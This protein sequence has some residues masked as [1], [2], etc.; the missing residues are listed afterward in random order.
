MT[1]IIQFLWDQMRADLHANTLPQLQDACH[2][3]A[4]GAVGSLTDQQREDLE[5]LERSVLKL[6]RRIEGEPI[7][8]SNH[9]EAAHALRGPLN[10]IIGFSRL[11]LKGIDGPFT[12]AQEK[13]LQTVYTIGRQLLTVF[14]LLLDALLLIAHDISFDFERVRV[15]APLEELIATG[16]TLADNHDFAFE[17]DIASGIP[18][19]EVETNLKRLKQALTALLAT[20]VKYTGGNTIVLRAWTSEN[21]LLIQLETP[22]CKLPTPLPA[23]LPDLLTD[24]ADPSFPYDAHLRLGLVWHFLAEMKGRLDAQESN[25][26]T[27]F[28]IA[29]G[30][31]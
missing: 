19:M 6:A 3:L 8:W 14:N 30:M 29:L 13:A 21:E 22:I 9:G 5:S 7:N 27:T 26:M 2:S 1:E 18:E 24:K 25:G 16:H 20:S 28:T 10:S 31:L 15:G 11:M 12:D 23:K 4:T 17:I